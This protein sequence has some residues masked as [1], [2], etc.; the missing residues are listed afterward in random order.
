MITVVDVEAAGRALRAG[1]LSCPL[2]GCAGILRVW[3]SARSRP[4]RAVDGTR[5]TLTPRRARCRVCSVTQTLL[6]AWCVP[7]HGYDVEVIG[8]G[9]LAAAEG[10]G[11]RRVAARL[12]VPPS[13]VRGWLAAVRAGSAALTARVVP[14]IEAAGARTH[15]PQAPPPWQGQALPEAVAA[16]GVAARGFA[17]ALATARPVGPGGYLSGIDYLTILAERHRRHLHEGLRGADPTG[18]LPQL[19]GWALIN[20]LTRGRLLTSTGPAG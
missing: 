5:V 1:Q 16:L 2:D 13:T 20:V 6:P 11:Y 8:A 19:R 4:V 18:V 7:R 15:P 9:L 17:L 10:G 12:R 3:S 14:F